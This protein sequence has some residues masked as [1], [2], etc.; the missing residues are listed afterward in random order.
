MD[1]HEA[2][3]ALLRWANE[4]E[5]DA[6]E[7]LGMPPTKITSEGLN[8]KDLRFSSLMVEFNVH[9]EIPL[10]A[11]LLNNHI[12]EESIWRSLKFIQYV[13]FKLTGKKL[14][15]NIVHVDEIAMSAVDFLHDV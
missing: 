11:R 4:M 15:T 10:V 1:N 2:W 12:M 14:E 9:A 13:A 7:L 5:N 3:E 6:I 8:D